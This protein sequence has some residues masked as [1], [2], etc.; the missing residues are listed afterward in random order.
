MKKDNMSGAEKIMLG[1]LEDA[2]YG[3]LEDAGVN[4]LEYP[5]EIIDRKV[6]VCLNKIKKL[7]FLDK[8]RCRAT[9]K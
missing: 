8:Y 9:G 2:F 4:E 6:K 3:L 7:G 5:P 1:V